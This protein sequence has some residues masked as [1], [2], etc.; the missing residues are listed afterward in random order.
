MDEK[1]IRRALSFEQIETENAAIVNVDCT[2]R[3]GACG[4]FGLAGFAA[5]NINDLRQPRRHVEVHVEADAGPCLALV[6]AMRDGPSDIGGHGEKRS[7]NGQHLAERL[8]QIRGR[9]PPIP[10]RRR[11]LSIAR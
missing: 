2:G 7:V 11:P 3:D 4:V 5:G 1:R 6:G 10:S 8:G 9:G